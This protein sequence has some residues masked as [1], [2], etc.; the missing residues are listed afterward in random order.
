MIF[1]S[2][3][4]KKNGDR[5]GFMKKMV[6]TFDV[7]KCE[8]VLAGDSVTVSPASSN[9]NAFSPTDFSSLF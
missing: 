8:L 7:K 1:T 6:L 2:L 5:E 4:K 3:A 9:G